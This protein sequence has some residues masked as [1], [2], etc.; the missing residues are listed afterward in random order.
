MKK[1]FNATLS[2]KYNNKYN[3]DIEIKEI[4]VHKKQRHVKYQ[5]NKI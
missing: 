1:W 3:N 2:V 5:M 4:N